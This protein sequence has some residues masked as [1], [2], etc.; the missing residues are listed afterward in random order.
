MSHAALEGVSCPTLTSCFA[1]GYHGRAALA[2]QWSGSAWG[3]LPTKRTAGLASADGFTH[4]SC[5]S[6]A[7]CVAVG[8]RYHAK[9]KY[10]DKTLVELWNGH[11]WKVQASL[12]N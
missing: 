7:S 9:V 1:A 11:S 4:V 8:Y 2:E 6:P 12:N 3:T 10:S 5:V